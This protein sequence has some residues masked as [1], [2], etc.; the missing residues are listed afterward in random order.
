MAMLALLLPCL[1]GEQADDEQH[2][3]SMLY[4]THFHYPNYHSH[5]PHS[6]TPHAHFPHAHAPHSHSP[7]SELD[8][9]STIAIGGSSG[10]SAIPSSPTSYI[11]SVGDVLSFSYSTAH[12][13]W[14]METESCDFSSGSA[15][16]LATNTQGGGGDG[17]FANLYETTIN[18]PGTYWFACSK[19]GG[20]HC[21]AGQKISVVVEEASP[22]A[23]TCSF[24]KS[25]SHK[26]CVY[27]KCSKKCNKASSTG[28]DYC[29]TSESLPEEDDAEATCEDKSK[30]CKT[31]HCKK[32]KKAKKCLLTCAG[33]EHSSC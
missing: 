32:E 25:K 13:V 19:G 30:K 6:H 4:S 23:S 15:T 26:K 28:D 10:W 12:D 1:A 16:E 8:A 7:S 11:V 33:T 5:N 14:R 22:P 24:K 27:K 20:A 29:C 21:E 31:K 2:G 9:T 18:E 3:R 17:G